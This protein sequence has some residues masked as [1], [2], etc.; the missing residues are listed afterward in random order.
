MSKYL[1]DLEAENDV[2][3]SLLRE[4]TFEVCFPYCSSQTEEKWAD[5]E[6]CGECWAKKLVAALKKK[7]DPETILVLNTRRF[8]DGRAPL[9]PAVTLNNDV[10]RTLS[11][12]E[13]MGA[14]FALE[15]ANKQIKEGVK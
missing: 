8:D 11:P 9:L 3:R 15:R 4:A 14:Q 5:P 6:K 2:L 7:R 10:I 13:I 12:I 1:D